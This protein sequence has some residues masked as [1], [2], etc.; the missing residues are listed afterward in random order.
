M[1]PKL[2]HLD[3]Q[4]ETLREF[5]DSYSKEEFSTIINSIRSEIIQTFNKSN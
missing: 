3:N 1:S 4:L 2:Q 5:K